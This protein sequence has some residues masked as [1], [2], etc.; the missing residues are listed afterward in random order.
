MIR[1]GG[2][3]QVN[4][5][6]Q[7]AV[8]QAGIRTENWPTIGGLTI[9]P[10]DDVIVPGTHI[11]VGLATAG[12]NIDLDG[13]VVHYV[14]NE[15]VR[16]EGRSLLASAVIS[17]DLAEN[18]TGTGIEYNVIVEP[19]KLVVRM[20]EVVIR[21]FLDDAVPNFAAEY[22]NN[23]EQYLQTDSPGMRRIS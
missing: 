12:F 9:E 20:A 16:I 14:V 22:R 13:K 5:F 11:N 6:R 23:V 8:F 2:N 18:E 1:I 7:P 10:R 15:G 17:L 3:E 21:K 4:G 19:R